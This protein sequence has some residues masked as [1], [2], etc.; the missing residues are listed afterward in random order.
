MGDRVELEGITVDCIVGI[1]EPEQ[2]TL[3]PV[4]VDVSM[5]VDLEGAFDGDLAQTVDYADVADVV[6]FLAQHGQWRLIESLAAAIARLVLA[7]PPPAARRPP[8]DEVTV[9]VRK[10]AIL[11][12]AVP[13][14][15][16][17]RGSDWCDLRT[18]MV[19][20]KTWVDTLVETPQVAAYRAHVEPE[21]SWPVPAG[22]AVMV[23]TGAVRAGGRTLAPGARLAR[24]EVTEVKARGA[25]PSTLLVVATPPLGAEPV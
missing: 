5:T 15:A 21:S 17:T 12:R 2:R 6:R 23:L 8:V 25:M 14:V 20:E 1:T 3:Q 19:P 18:R 7:P 13:G 22:A 4:V 24:G 9:R 11:D 10:P 16:I